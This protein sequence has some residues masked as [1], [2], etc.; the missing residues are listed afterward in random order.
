MMRDQNRPVTQSIIEL[1]DYL[2]EHLQE[3][4]EESEVDEDAEAGG[5]R[6][7]RLFR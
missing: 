4:G 5:L 2:L 6:L 7:S 3:T 1:A